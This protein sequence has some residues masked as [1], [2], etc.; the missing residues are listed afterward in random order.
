MYKSTGY[1]PKSKNKTILL[2]DPKKNIENYADYSNI[3]D[4]KTSFN[5]MN[6]NIHKRKNK[7]K[8]NFKKKF[9]MLRNFS[10]K[11]NEGLLCLESPHR[12]TFAKRILSEIIP[13]K[14]DKD[15]K[16][17]VYRIRKETF[18]SDSSLLILNTP[19]NHNSFIV[20]KFFKK[21]SIKDLIAKR[22]SQNIKHDFINFFNKRTMSCKN[23]SFTNLPNH[24][25]SFEDIIEEDNN[26]TEEE[27][28]ILT[29]K[30]EIPSIKLN[31]KKVPFVQPKKISI[32]NIKNKN[33]T[34]TE[35]NK[36]ESIDNSNNSKHKIKKIAKPFT[37][38][39]LYLKKCDM[40]K[41][42]CH[43]KFVSNFLTPINQ[44]MKQ[45]FHITNNEYENINKKIHNL[46]YLI[47]NNDYSV[48][49]NKRK[50]EKYKNF[51]PPKIPN[52]HKVIENKY[53]TIINELKNYKFKI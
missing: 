45:D 2:L 12:S 46:N 27:F 13:K 4:K 42:Y 15:N 22:K 32:N 21:S 34:K 17:L 9:K 10:S 16:K 20:N 37:P 38:Q 11:F 40:K 39:K 52:I 36:K 29:K 41:H 8:K 30:K 47:N 49:K 26:N 18:D 28:F 25:N 43:E 48:Y 31:L 1:I 19:K 33:K 14:L 44:F 3:K 5:Q 6:N 23:I 35:N 7:H 51:C 50:K 53:F 24:K